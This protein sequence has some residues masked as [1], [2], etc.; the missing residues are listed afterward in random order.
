M[1]SSTI[2]LAMLFNG[3]LAYLVFRARSQIRRFGPAMIGAVAC[4]LAT[5]VFGQFGRSEPHFSALF[6]LGAAVGFFMLVYALWTR[7]ELLWRRDG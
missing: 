5:V 7:R 2:V 4:S 1:S 6:T 3:Y